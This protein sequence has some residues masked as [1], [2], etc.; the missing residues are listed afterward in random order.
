MIT[1]LMVVLLAL[2]ALGGW[3]IGVMTLAG[4]AIAKRR[5]WERGAQVRAIR[6]VAELLESEAARRQAQDVI[7]G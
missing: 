6:Y 1:P 4:Y 7:E 3:L 5:Q 2:A